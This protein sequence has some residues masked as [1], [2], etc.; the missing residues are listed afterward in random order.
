M[1]AKHAQL[2]EK[3]FAECGRRRALC[4]YEK[5]TSLEKANYIGSLNNL[6]LAEIR[7]RKA[8][9]ALNHWRQAVRLATPS[10]E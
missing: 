6:A 8:D 2:A 9:A 10:P 1:F 7:L 5:L 4:S 3:H